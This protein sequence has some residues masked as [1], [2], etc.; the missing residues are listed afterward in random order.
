MEESAVF[1]G[2]LGVNEDHIEGLQFS[3]MS[4]LEIQRIIAMQNE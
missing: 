4:A 3:T 1:F 2:K